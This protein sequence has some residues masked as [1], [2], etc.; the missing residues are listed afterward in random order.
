MVG[1]QK[2]ALKKVNHQSLQGKVNDSCPRHLLLI[3]TIIFLDHRRIMILNQ[4]Q[5]LTIS[6]PGS[7]APSDSVSLSF[8]K[9]DRIVLSWISSKPSFN[10]LS[11]PLSKSSLSWATCEK[12]DK[13]RKEG[14]PSIQTRKIHMKNKSKIYTSENQHVCH[15]SKYNIIKK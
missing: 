5:V 8:S 7:P 11:R 12:N 4:E 2:K 3:I 9:W 15:R 1:R 10:P 6:S 13:L 14:K